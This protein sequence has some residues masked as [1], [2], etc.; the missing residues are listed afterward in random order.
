MLLSFT[1]RG[2]YCAQADVY[3]DPW[4]PVDKAL[5]THAHSDHARWGMKQYLAHHDSLGVMRLRLGEDIEI[6][7][8]SYGE[9]RYINGVEI[10]FHPA[11][12]IYIP[13]S[14]R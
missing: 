8:V 13:R 9:T 1:E 5:I 11:G 14:G 7:G 12:H 4:K 6:E 10:S 2:I 3:I